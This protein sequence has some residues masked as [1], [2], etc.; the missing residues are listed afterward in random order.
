MN[1]FYTSR[2]PS[3]CAQDLDDKRVVKMVLETAQLLSAAAASWGAVPTYKVT[4]AKHPC[5]RW[6]GETKGNYRWTLSLF[7]SLGKEYTHRYGKIHKSMALLEELKG[8]EVFV[9]TFEDQAFD[10]PFHE[11]PA[12]T[13]GIEFGTVM[14]RYR[15][16]M[17][18]KWTEDK[19]PPKWTNR[20]PPEWCDTTSVPNEYRFILV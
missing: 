8:F 11:P 19:Q 10:G 17:C 5:T 9:E 6:V 13:P 1:I 14:H 18:K 20:L 12:C 7:E 15:A 3:Y 4:H 2:H 16:Y